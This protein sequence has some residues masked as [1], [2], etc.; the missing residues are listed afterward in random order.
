MKKVITN[1]KGQSLVE[2]VIAMTILIIATSAAM[3]VVVSSKN[4]LYMAEGQTKAT[5]LAQEGIEIVRNN[6]NVGCAF[7]DLTTP[8]KTAND[9]GDPGASCHAIKSDTDNTSDNSIIVPTDCT[10]ASSQIE[11]Y[12]GF[13]RVVYLYDLSN[14]AFNGWATGFGSGFDAKDKYYN[15]VVKVTWID[16]TGSRSTEISTIMLKKWKD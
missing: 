5:A 9:P 3:T 15:I 14:A 4:L 7:N 11:N 6:R 12:S 10:A 13:N 2:V 16:K 8:P 1:K